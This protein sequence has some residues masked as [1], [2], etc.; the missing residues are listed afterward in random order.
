MT[1]AWI[2]TIPLF[3]VVG[4]RKAEQQPPPAGPDQQ[5]GGMWGE[6]DQTGQ[7]PT[8]QPGQQPYDQTPYGQQPSQ[9][10]QLGQ[11]GQQPTQPGQMG[12][13]GQQ[14]G[15]LGQAAQPA[16]QFAEAV[17]QVRTYAQEI[18][19]S[20][21]LRHENIVEGFN[22]ITTAISTM[23]NAAG[24]DLTSIRTYTDQ[25]ATS[26]PM[27]PEHTGLV[28]NALMQTVGTLE[29]LARQQN[30]TGMD[31]N[32]TQIRTQIDAIEEGTP[33][34]EQKDAVANS[35]DQLA[36]FMNDMSQRPATGTQ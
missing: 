34:L 26:D 31:Q 16:P 24:V 25:L 14:P 35:F 28:K 36:Q 1:K 27:S 4:C 19:A 6:L 22:A 21:D 2:L 15:Q 18:R 8:Q 33:L 9:P 13:P 29:N 3:I 20:Q 30:I 11:Q 5:Q 7:Q 12:Q 32:L 23:P 17:N 10:G